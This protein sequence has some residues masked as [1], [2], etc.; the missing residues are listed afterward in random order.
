MSTSAGLKSAS[1]PPWSKMAS[2]VGMTAK[3]LVRVWMKVRS[4]VSAA[5]TASSDSAW[6]CIVPSSSGP[7]TVTSNQCSSPAASVH[8]RRNRPARAPS[9]SGNIVRGGQLWA[10]SC[11]RQA[12]TRE[13]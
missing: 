5:I 8:L 4:V 2:P 12:L 3:L 1:R 7:V 11:P 13:R 9:S 6:P 10:A